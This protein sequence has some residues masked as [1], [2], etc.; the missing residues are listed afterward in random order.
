MMDAHPAIRTLG[1]IHQFLECLYEGKSCS[2]GRP[3]ES[4]PYWGPIVKRMR[5]GRQEINS[6]MIQQMRAERH[7]RVP[8]LLM[9]I[10]PP[11]FYLDNQHFLFE[12]IIDGTNEPILLDSSKYIARYLLLGKSPDITMKGIYLTR[13]VR[14]VIYSFGKQVQ[15]SRNPFSAIYYYLLVNLFSQ[16]VCWVD[17]RVLKIRYEDLVNEPERI[18]SKLGKHIFDT[19][20][21][22]PFPVKDEYPMPHIIGGNRMRSQKKI[23]VREDEAW[24]KGIPRWKQVIYYLAAAPVMLLN[25]YRI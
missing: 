12:K 16:L 20:A 7:V 5:M 19:E 3:L 4:C 21:Q 11:P 9:R 17:P 24:K 10:K 2:C 6:Q 8:C 18:L 1:E 25:G 22:T 23:R 14:G 15:T 13:D